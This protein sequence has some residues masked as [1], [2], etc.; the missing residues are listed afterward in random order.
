MLS[1]LG[2][3][4]V[5][6][7]SAVVCGMTLFSLQA[8]GQIVG[9]VGTTKEPWDI[10]ARELSFDQ[11]TDTYTAIGDVVIKKEGSVLKCDYAQVDRKTM[12]AYARG[13]VEL[14]SKGD[15]LRGDELTVDLKKY[16]GE[17]K[18]GRLFLKK[19]NYHVTG[20][21]IYKTGEETYRVL[22]GTVTS[23][24]GEKVPW[25]ISA[26]E[27]DVTV[28]GYG[29]AW[30]PALRIREIPI[31]YSP[32]MI[33]PAKTTRQ[34]GILTPEYIDS[35][36]DGLSI[37]VP[38]YWVISDNA[39]ATFNEYYMSRRGLMQG[40]EFRYALSPLSKGT[41]MVDYLYQD[42]VS[43]DEYRKGNI[44]SPYSDRYWFR[45]KINQELP[46]KMDL[47]L[48]LDWVS[49]RDY[50]KE[51]KTIPTGLDR[52]RRMFLTEFNRDLE[53]ETVLN[54]RNALLV[55][56][57]FGMSSFSGGVNYYQNTDPTQSN[58]NQLPYARYDMTKQVLAKS[59]SENLF[60][61][62]ASSFNNYWRETLDRGQVLDLTP[63]V[64]YPLKVKNYLN[65][66][67]S[68]GVTETLFQVD[69]KQS[70]S[71]E[72]FGNRTVPNFRV[73]S[74]TDFQK[75][76][77]V[78]GT[79]VQKI[80][81]NI[82]P[83][84]IYNYIPEIKQDNLPS[85][86]S[87]ISKTNTVT[88]LLINTLTSKSI[89]KKGKGEYTRE[90]LLMGSGEILDDGSREDLYGYLDFFRFQLSQTYDINEAQ[91]DI[92]PTSSQDRRPF[93]NVTGELDIRPGPYFNWRSAASWSPYSGQ[94]DSH[95]HSL[96][97]TDPKGNRAYVEY[98]ASS[99]DQ[100]RQINSNL[101]WRITPIWTINFL[102][103]YSL[104]QN[105]NYET[106]AG[107]SYNKQCWGIKLSYTST[108]DNTT[109]LVS[110]SLK[111]LAEF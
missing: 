87:P 104:D 32:Y 23:C 2:R 96:I 21:Q 50:L 6:I 69:N 105:K 84:V 73:D 3:L 94:M 67:G 47:K 42:G 12:I 46:A 95:S 103:K 91:R 101:F 110:F 10:E 33:F 66:E 15:E 11:D 25:A 86:V 18:K 77:D 88:Y 98:L 7:F 64:Y 107:L 29:Q 92:T 100:I 78:S 38:I 22:N 85:F 70:S 44:S 14:L 93:S 24:D 75:I 57:N 111:G 31:L 13:K 80:K 54:R 26:K 65:L 106:T 102:N 4:G 52:N 35:S 55:S 41:L 34:S 71:V 61:Q 76:F 43:K 37:N 89:T 59:F 28:D 19:N 72:A 63:T 49:D 82:R 51:F 90:E 99:G 39:D 9:S 56:K 62:F 1:G 8:E 68:V 58:L 40:V 20:E 108:P 17:V 53:D 79:T 60:F 74:S 97:I 27:I 81:H 48:D 30:N 36:R 83:Q 109:Y 16:T 5:I 45:S